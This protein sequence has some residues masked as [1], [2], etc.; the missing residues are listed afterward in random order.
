MHSFM[1]SCKTALVAG[2]LRHQ[3][4]ALNKVPSAQDANWQWGHAEVFGR[5]EKK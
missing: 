1:M 5:G 2:P 4:M 3:L